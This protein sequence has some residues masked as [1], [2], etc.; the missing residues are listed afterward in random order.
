MQEKSQK[1]L[2]RGILLILVFTVTLLL[3]FNRDKVQAF[4]HYGYP[5]IFL[6]SVLS[7]ATLIFPIPGVVFTSAMGAVFNPKF[8]VSL[9]D[10]R[11]EYAADAFECL[12]DLF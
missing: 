8:Y 3:F 6:V 2:L 5:G 9:E 12:G 4:S 10:W 7:N 11:I 1:I